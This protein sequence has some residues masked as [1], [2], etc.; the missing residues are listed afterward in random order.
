MSVNKINTCKCNRKYYKN[1][2]NK[3]Y[4]KKSPY[5]ALNLQMHFVQKIQGSSSVYIVYYSTGILWLKIAAESMLQCY[6]SDQIVVC[7]SNPSFSI[8]HRR[9]EPL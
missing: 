8:Y 5:K 4:H 3:S 6:K 7:V 9:G 1:K 2:S